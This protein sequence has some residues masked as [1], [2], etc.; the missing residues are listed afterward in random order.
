[1][2]VCVC[3]KATDNAEYQPCCSAHLLCV[4]FLQSCAKQINDDDDDDD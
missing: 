3:L 1:M 2:C 4:A